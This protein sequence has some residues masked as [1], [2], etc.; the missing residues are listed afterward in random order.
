MILRALI[1][2]ML[3]FDHPAFP[4]IAVER[5]ERRVLECFPLAGERGATLRAAL[6]A[7][8]RDFTAAS[9]GARFATAPLDARRAALRRWAQSDVPAQR[10]FY[11]GMKRLVLIPAYALPELRRAVG[12]AE[13]E[14]T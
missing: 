13:E 10:R 8:D 5:V 12:A 9:G 2:A 7:F 6:A 14:P 11:A 3:A 4:A 1:E